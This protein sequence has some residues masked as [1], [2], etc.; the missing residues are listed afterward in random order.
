MEAFH[1]LGQLL[2]Q[3][4]S[5]TRLFTA[6]ACAID[7]A[8]AHGRRARSRSSGRPFVPPMSP[9]WLLDHEIASSKHQGA[10]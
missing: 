2:P 8:L 10:G 1:A 7:T 5:A 4:P 6:A 3:W 9:Q